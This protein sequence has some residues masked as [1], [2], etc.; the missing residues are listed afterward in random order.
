M[1]PNL[2]QF[3]KSLRELRNQFVAMTSAHRPALWSYC[4]KLTGSPWDAED[5]VQETMLKAFSPISEA[6]PMTRHYN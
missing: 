2:E 4:L 1:E 5:L 6:W 3:E